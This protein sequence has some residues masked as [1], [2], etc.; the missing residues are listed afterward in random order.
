MFGKW[1]KQTLFCHS[2]EVLNNRIK[3]LFDT[4]HFIIC[5]SVLNWHSLIFKSSL[6][7]VFATFIQLNLQKNGGRT[8]GP[9]YHWKHNADKN[10]QGRVTH[11]RHRRS[12]VIALCLLEIPVQWSDSAKLYTPVEIKRHPKPLEISPRVQLASLQPPDK[13]R[14]D[15]QQ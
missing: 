2:E 1:Q 5:L 9:S 7:Q 6:V 10:H 4:A 3:I 15:E 13:S 11:W 12:M 8:S 14:K